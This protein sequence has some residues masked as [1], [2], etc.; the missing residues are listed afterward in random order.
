MSCP[1]NATGTSKQGQPV[2]VTWT[3]PTTSGGQAPVST[4]CAPESGS[5]FPVGTSSV[6]CKASDSAAQSTACT[7]SVV[8]SAAPR[9]SVTKFMGFG[10]SLTQ[11]VDSPPAPATIWQLPD[12]PFAYPYKL[13]DLLIARYTDQTITVLNDGWWGEKIDEGLARLPSE[14]RYY[15]PEALLLLEG[16]NDLLASPSDP[17]TTY[18]ARKLDEMIRVA[19]LT[20]P[21]I[22]VFLATFPPQYPGERGAGAP[23]VA[24]L[25]SKIAQEATANGVILVDLY[26]D[27]ATAGTR[28]IGVDGLHP[29]DA[30]FT[31]MAKSFYAAVAANLEVKPGAVQGIRR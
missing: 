16:A 10:D 4:S 12:W 11:G 13:G 24:S 6:A 1:A 14:I 2:T 17:T 21:G 15:Q 23:Y 31:Q 9:L 3:A 19:R 27:F 28:L 20:R 29:T 30:G 25:N 7:F 26:K 5:A 18:I 22:V 8:I